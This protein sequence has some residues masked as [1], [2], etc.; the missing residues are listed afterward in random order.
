MGLKDPKTCSCIK[1]F[2]GLNTIKTKY[3]LV[4]TYFKKGFSP[5]LTS[6]IYLNSQRTPKTFI[7]PY[8][9]LKLHMIG[10]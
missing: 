8:R 10:Q 9:H 5:I 1:K 3:L 4:K 6:K 2:R 7:I